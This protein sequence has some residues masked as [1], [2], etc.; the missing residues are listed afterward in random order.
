MHILRTDRAREY[1]DGHCREYC[2]ASGVTI[3]DSVSHAPELN[4][5]AE[6]MNRTISEKLRALLF[7]AELGPEY[8]TYA[9][10]AA[11]YIINRSPSRANPECATPFEVW[12]G[13]KPTYKYIRIFG[14]VAERYIPAAVRNITVAQTR[15]TGAPSDAKL[16]PRSERRILIG[17]TATGYQVI[18]PQTKKLTPSCDVRF[19]ENRNI[20]TINEKP[21]KL[22]PV[23]KTDQAA[24][25]LAK[26]DPAPKRVVPP[27]VDHP[28]AAMSLLAA[29]PLKPKPLL[30]ECVP[31][32]FTEIA[33]NPHA[34]KWRKAVATELSAMMENGVF[35]PILRTKNMRLVDSK[36]LFTIKYDRDGNPY[37]KARLV[38]RGFRDDTAYCIYE[39]YS[40]VVN[41]WL[42][43]WAIALAN[44]HGFKLTK[45][46]V[47]TAFLN[48]DLQNVVYLCVPEGM[49]AENHETALELKKSI[50]GLRP[51]SKNWYNLVNETAL[52][53]GFR[54]SHADRCLYHQTLADGT[55]AIL[56]V[57]VDDMLLVTGSDTLIEQTTSALQQRFQI[58]IDEDPKFFVGFEIQR[59][60]NEKT[61]Q[62]TQKKYVERMLRRFNMNTAHPQSTPMEVGL[63]LA[64]NEDGRDDTEFRSMIGGLLYLAR[65]TR[66]D[67]A[68][69]VNALS[70]AQAAST[71]IEKNYVRRIFRYLVGTQDYAL[72]YTGIGE[73][74]DAY[75]DASYAP[76][77]TVPTKKLD[78]NKGKSI[79]GYLLRM[80]EDPILWAVKKQTIMA[81]S[82]TAAEVIAIFD[83]L[84][85][86]CVARHIMGEILRMAEPV[87]IFED[88][89]SATRIVMGGE[90]KN[91]RSILIKCYAVL[92]AVEN[93]E[94]RVENVAAKDQWADALT[95][96]LDREKL[97]VFTAKMFGHVKKIQK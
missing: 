2:K 40:P 28:Y 73:K 8:W 30:E 81:T 71:E 48:A 39:T 91:M 72:T 82:S 5:V 32:S 76:N 84:D 75:V 13:R 9:I 67:I 54:R 97:T 58:T 69:A 43:R 88:N 55:V 93:K 25:S 1:V 83:A 56:L 6:R 20:R 31:K 60:W 18:D 26:T 68:F 42:I 89:T 29:D 70:R 78:L 95:K 44:K 38:A 46:D 4:G 96:A 51:S 77:I 33:G 37:A 7:D 53:L 27:I 63:R 24:S 11:V 92:I 52:T 59:N 16:V 36:W 21:E 62:L 74:L 87:T 41:W 49:T 15:R 34:D 17:Y 57:Y 61:I 90:Q 80:Y 66:P 86:I 85:N 10:K 12:H 47:S 50:Y 3:E 94:I 45:Y 35:K 64:E 79:T 65:G 22:L 19:D 23:P 14:C